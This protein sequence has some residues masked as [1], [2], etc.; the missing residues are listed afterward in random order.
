MKLFSPTLLF[1]RKSSWDLN[2]KNEYN[3]LVNRQKMIFQVSD[4]KGKY[5]LN[6]VDNDNNTIK[7][8]YIKEGLQLKYFGHSNSLCTRALRAIT[9][10][11]PIDEYRLRF[12]LRKEFSC[13]CGQYLIK[14]RHHILHECK[15]FNK[16]QNSRKDSIGHFILFLELNPNAFAFPKPIT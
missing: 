1:P 8:S 15:R 2:K 6:L 9:N 7:P 14:T 13:P 5:F 3:N 10:H 11:A 4:I 16:Y 12:F